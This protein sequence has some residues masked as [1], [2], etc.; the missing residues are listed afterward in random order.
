MYLPSIVHLHCLENL[1]LNAIV[2]VMTLSL[3]AVVLAIK[4]FRLPSSKIL[5]SSLIKSKLQTD[6]LTIIALIL[7]LQKSLKCDKLP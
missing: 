7:L 5:E 1:K 2:I 3:I 6:P 4:Y